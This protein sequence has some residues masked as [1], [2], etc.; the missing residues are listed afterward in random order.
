MAALTPKKQ[1][2]KSASSNCRI[3][4]CS[5]ATKFG[6]GK[7]GQ[8]STENQFETSIREGSRGTKLAIMCAA[9][10]IVIKKL[11]YLSDRVCNF[12]G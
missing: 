3:C 9:V 12:C 2:N 5:V 10:G 6:T 4:N 11:P 1:A 8:I 7:L